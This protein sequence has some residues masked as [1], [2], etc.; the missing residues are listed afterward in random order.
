V[1]GATSH[2]V[3]F[4]VFPGWIVPVI[5]PVQRSHVEPS[6]MYKYDG[7]VAATPLAVGTVGV[8]LLLSACAVAAPEDSSRP[9]VSVRKFRTFVPSLPA[10]LTGFPETAAPAATFPITVHGDPQGAVEL[11]PPPPLLPPG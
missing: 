2:G 7:N 1:A 4:G 9:V 5:V 8:L 6:K 3:V 11:P 10:T